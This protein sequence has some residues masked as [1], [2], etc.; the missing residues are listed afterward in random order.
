MKP[1]V[2]L[3]K[4]MDIEKSLKEAI[5][6]QGGME[7]VIPRGSRVLIK[8]NFT[9]A[10]PPE[11]GAA[12]DPK[13]VEELAR[14]TLEAGASRVIIAE[15]IGAGTVS[16]KDVKGLKKISGFKGIEII[17]L[18][19]APVEGVKVKNP[20]VVEQFEVPRV[21]MDSDV[22]INLAKL[23]VHPMAAFTL[24]MKNLMGALPGRSFRNPQEARRL[25]YL[26]PT[27]PGGGKKIFHDLARD[28]GIETMH[29][30]FVDLNS[31]IHSHLCVIDGLYGM[32]GEGAPVSGKS[33][34]MDLLILGTDLVATEAV[35]ATVMG[36][37]PR[38]FSYLHHAVEK[39]LGSKFQPEEIEIR[40][41]NLKKVIRRFEP[42]SAAALWPGRL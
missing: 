1:V 21:V 27:L 30:A 39:G 15:A 3:I 20:L 28:R 14:L 33:V 38:S 8:P 29:Q 22:L 36:F 25:G 34:K 32:E 35:G 18:N 16:M 19:D 42:A 13:I 5:E 9:G 4:G 41:E 23:K 10:L 24:C 11:T 31:A 7:S 17:D 26:T 12:C 6:Y 2:S 40:G 37:D